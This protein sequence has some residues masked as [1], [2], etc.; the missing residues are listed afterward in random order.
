VGYKSS[1]LDEMI[2]NCK[3][4]DQSHMF[5]I[6]DHEAWSLLSATDGR[7]RNDMNYSFRR[8]PEQS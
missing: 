8:S 3:K 1:R 7:A 2:E 4:N 5:S 6:L